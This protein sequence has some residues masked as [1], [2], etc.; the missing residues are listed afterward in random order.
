MKKKLLQLYEGEK[1]GIE[2]GRQEGI[3]I[4]KTEVAKKSL[5]MGMKVEDVAQATDLEVGLI[6]KLKEERGKI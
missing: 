3:L 5:K 4:G 2:K 6:D 1:K